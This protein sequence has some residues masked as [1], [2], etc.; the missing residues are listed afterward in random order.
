MS[1]YKRILP[2]AL[3]ALV[4]AASVVIVSVFGIRKPDESPLPSEENSEVSH[5]FKDEIRAPKNMKGVWIPYMALQLEENEVTE[6]N[7]RRKYS[8]LID[9]CAEKG[10]NTV[11]VQVRPFSDAIYPSK[12]FPMSHIISGK[13]GV[14]VDFDP[15]KIMIDCAHEKGLSVHAWINPFRISTGETPSAISDDNPC[16]QLKNDDNHQY[17]FNC[18]KGLY[19]NP[20]DSTVRKLIIDGVK[21][22]LENYE[23]EGI[24]IDDYFYPE[25]SEGCDS[26]S[27]EM[28]LKT[29]SEGCVPL[30]KDEW[31]KNNVNMLVAEIWS[32]VHQKS[33]KAVFG[34]APQC[35]FENNEI[36]GADVIKWCSE[37]GYADYICPQLYVSMEHPV[38]PFRKLASQWREK[39]TNSSTALYFGLG[40]YKDGTDA[41]GGTWLSRKDNISAEINCVRELGAD[42][43]ILYS[44]EFLDRLK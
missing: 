25:E 38:F 19:Y 17:T 30:S 34:I 14:S 5:S 36:I 24:Q 42:G 10:L 28:Y 7:C 39:V 22:L 1:F 6:E 26:Q 3:C 23:I 40:I 20:A 12:L 13:Q 18:G 43:Y 21:E 8:A 31:R 37:N 29:V 35:N 41:D 2:Y 44:C 15:L 4:L 9:C 11:I 32:T 33:G 27:Y 16:V